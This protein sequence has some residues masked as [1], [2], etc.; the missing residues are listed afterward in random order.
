MSYFVG[1]LLTVFGNC[2][3]LGMG[4]ANGMQWP[5]TYIHIKMTFSWLSASTSN[6]FPLSISFGSIPF[7]K[8]KTIALQDPNTGCRN[9]IP[10]SSASSAADPI[11]S[12]GGP[13]P[14]SMSPSMGPMPGEYAM[15]AGYPVSFPWSIFMFPFRWPE[16]IFREGL[17]VLA[18]ERCLLSSFKCHIGWDML[19]VSFLSCFQILF[20]INECAGTAH[21]QMSPVH[22]G[23]MG[24]PS[25]MPM[26]PMMRQFSQVFQWTPNFVY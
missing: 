21:P 8:I 12:M 1:K 10:M 3:I 4:S 5:K 17:M 22:S 16:P 24:P 14:S 20:L 11:S 18:R 13:M 23:A 19:P 26:A 25:M 15:A 9:A 2:H 6:P 7:E